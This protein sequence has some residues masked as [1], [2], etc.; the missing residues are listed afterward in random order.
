[1]DGEEKRREE[2]DRNGREWTEVDGERGVDEEE[3]VD[4]NGQSMDG[5]GRASFFSNLFLDIHEIS[6]K[7]SFVH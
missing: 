4:S 7:S 6:V 5:S 1:M 3:R 2:V